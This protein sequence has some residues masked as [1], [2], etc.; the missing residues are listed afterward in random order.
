MIQ[1][2]DNYFKLDT[3]NTSYLFEINREMAKIFLEACS[4]VNPYLKGNQTIV[5]L[6]SE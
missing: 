2:I 4:A 1:K 3:R 5:K 6:L